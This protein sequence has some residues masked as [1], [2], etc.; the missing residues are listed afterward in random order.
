MTPR[1]ILQLRIR[2]GD[3]RGGG[4]GVGCTVGRSYTGPPAANSTLWAHPVP[5]VA[6]QL[7]SQPT[8]GE[9]NVLREK[10]GTGRPPVGRCSK[11]G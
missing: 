3:I 11:S 4:L 10:P 8:P 9:G 1:A 6:H 7:L 5:P 2:D